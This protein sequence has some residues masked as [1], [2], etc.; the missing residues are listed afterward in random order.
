MSTKHKKL[1]ILFIVLLLL[2]SFS[3]PIMAQTAWTNY[4]NTN[5][6]EYGDVPTLNGIRC[7]FGN[8]LIVTLRLI[9]IGMF[10]MIVI[11]GFKLLTASGD[12][13]K[14]DAAKSTLTMAVVGLVMAILAWFILALISQLTGVDVTQFRFPLL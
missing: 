7:L 9:G 10:L 13:K 5:C 4:L 3:S 2:V 6:I 12:P 1:A 8:V 14:A 11:S